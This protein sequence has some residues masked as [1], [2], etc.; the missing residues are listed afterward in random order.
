M[1]LAATRVTRLA[2]SNEPSKETA[3]KNYRV[4]ITDPWASG[5]GVQRNDMDPVLAGASTS[6]RSKHWQGVPRKYPRHRRVPDT[7]RADALGSHTRHIHRRLLLGVVD[8]CAGGTALE[9]NRRQES[10]TYAE[11]LRGDARNRSHLACPTPGASSAPAARDRVRSDLAGPH[12]KA[13][14]TLL[15][16]EGS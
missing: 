12:T 14:L 8:R 13:P 3:W 2:K 4:G 15:T 5:V 7:C 16:T 9:T 1:L 10:A 6:S 11:D